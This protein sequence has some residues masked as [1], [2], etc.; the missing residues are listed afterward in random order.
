MISLFYLIVQALVVLR[1]DQHI[2]ARPTHLCQ[3][4]NVDETDRPIAQDN[5][6]VA[7]LADNWGVSL[8]AGFV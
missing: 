7:F 2:H 5:W 4:L 1:T 8:L 6:G 3:L